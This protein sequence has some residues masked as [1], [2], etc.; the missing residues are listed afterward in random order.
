MKE[1]TELNIIDYAV[2]QTRSKG[3]RFNSVQHITGALEQ[4]LINQNAN[5]FTSQNGARNY[6]RSLNRSDVKKEL[7]ANIIKINALK[8]YN[9]EATLLNTRKS[10]EDELSID[11]VE[12]VALNMI[13]N[14]SKEQIGSVCAKYPN[15]YKQLINSF[16]YRRYFDHLHNA[17]QLDSP[18]ILQGMYSFD[19]EKL[20]T[21]YSLKSMSNY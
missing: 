13:R 18:E 14:M 3:G 8:E 1:V 20:D 15:F 10:Y 5:G 9:H 11:E 19:M 4:Y 7:L 17:K 21:E 2:F 16:V 6:L 12:L